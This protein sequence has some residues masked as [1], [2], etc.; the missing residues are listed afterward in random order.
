MRGPIR[1]LTLAGVVL[2]A[3]LVLRQQT[4]APT[5]VSSE[6]LPPPGRALGAAGRI[7]AHHD[8]RATVTLVAPVGVHVADGAWV[9]AATDQH[10]VRVFRVEGSRFIWSATELPARSADAK[11]VLRCVRAGQGLA[12]EPDHR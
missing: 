9:I 12:G 8:Q 6:C 10:R 4:P 5:P 7:A 3:I 11:A 1:R 2:F